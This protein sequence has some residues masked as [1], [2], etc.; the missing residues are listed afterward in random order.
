MLKTLVTLIRGS[1]AA[2]DEEVA[3]RSALLIL[4]QQIRDSAAATERAKRAL[5]LAIAQDEAEAKRL[6][7]TLTRI[8][9]LENRAREALAANRDDLA[10]EAAEAIAVMEADRDAIRIA[11]ATFTRE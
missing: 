2:A 7:A 11:R 8:A 1:L 9:D 10:G 5:A 4:D 6:E 3:D